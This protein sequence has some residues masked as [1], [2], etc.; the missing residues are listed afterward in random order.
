MHTLMIGPRAFRQRFVGLPVWLGDSLLGFMGKKCLVHL[1]VLTYYS[2]RPPTPSDQPQS[3]AGNNTST[4]NGPREASRL[5]LHMK[6]ACKL[7][8]TAWGS[9]GPPVPGPFI[10][11]RVD[12][13]SQPGGRER[14]AEKEISYGLSESAA[15]AARCYRRR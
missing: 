11:Q 2:Y 6:E 14:E 4:N 9:S 15:A 7:I 3:S 10:S 13:G 8:T 5:D 1:H 12:G